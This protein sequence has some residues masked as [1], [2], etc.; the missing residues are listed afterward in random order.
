MSVTQQRRAPW[1]EVAGG[2]VNRTPGLGGRGFLL[3]DHPDGGM[4]GR[5]CWQKEER[6]GKS[7]ELQEHPEA[8]QLL[9]A[10]SLFSFNLAAITEAAIRV[11]PWCFFFF[12]PL[13]KRCRIL[14]PSLGLELVPPAVGGAES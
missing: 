10:P 7:R 4:E 3:Q 1:L 11:F 6:A 9:G 14:V 12:W 2:E 13:C 5:G 8:L